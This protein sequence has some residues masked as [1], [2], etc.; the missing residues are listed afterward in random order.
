MLWK[1]WM[2]MEESQLCNIVNVTYLSFSQGCRQSS[3]SK[4]L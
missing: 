3:K 2:V 4:A 1:I